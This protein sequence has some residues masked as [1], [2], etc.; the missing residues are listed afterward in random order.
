MG[1][2][3][4]VPGARA[5]HGVRQIRPWWLAVP[6]TQKPEPSAPGQPRQ[7]P[8][9]PVTLGSIALPISRARHLFLPW[10]GGRFAPGPG[11]RAAHILAVARDV[12]D[13][14]L[15]AEVFL[16]AIGGV[17]VDEFRQLDDIFAIRG[18]VLFQVA[19]VDRLVR[20]ALGAIGQPSGAGHIRA[21]VTFHD[22][23]LDGRSLVLRAVF[24]EHRRRR[25][26]GVTPVE[27]A[28]VE[29][30]HRQTDATANTP[31]L[32]EDRK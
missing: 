27:E 9:S 20:T 32:V 28:A 31:L 29:R 17:L 2:G 4:V 8:P 16:E 23:A 25:L 6:R 26:R 5:R 3:R 19:V 10:P 11:R 21:T 13:P 22:R 30:T 15:G 18:Q 12:V 14:R 1:S 7:T 24:H